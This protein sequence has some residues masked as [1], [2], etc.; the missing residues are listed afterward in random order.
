MK[1][2]PNRALDHLF[3]LFILNSQFLNF[4]FSC[5]LCWEC[6]NASVVFFGYSKHVNYRNRESSVCSINSVSLSSCILSLLSLVPALYDFVLFCSD[7][8]GVFVFVFEISC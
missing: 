6:A 1:P 8:F 5:Q 7:L 2:F 4:S 3:K